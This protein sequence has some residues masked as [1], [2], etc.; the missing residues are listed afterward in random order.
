MVELRQQLAEILQLFR[1][2]MLADYETLIESTLFLER[3]L[4]YIDDDSEEINR[5]LISIDGLLQNQVPLN[6]L[7]N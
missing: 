2:S 7:I 6:S 1:V 5:T 4:P 3:K